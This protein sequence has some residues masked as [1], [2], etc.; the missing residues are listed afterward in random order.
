MVAQ[1]RHGHLLITGR[2]G[3]GKTTLFRQLA[4]ALEPFHPV[5]FYTE[6]IREGGSRL[7]FAAVS[8][9]GR[10][11]LLSHVQLPGPP[12]VGRYGVDIAGFEQFLAGVNLQQAPSSLIMIDEIGKMETCSLNFRSTLTGLLE[13]SKVIVATIALRGGGLIGAI[14]QRS[15]CTLVEV[16]PSNRERLLAELT[17]RI[18]RELQ[19]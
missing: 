17:D 14:K 18:R 5:G 9:D 6:E 4:R 2:P 3:V 19:P 11:Q 15:D 10:R 1:S 7:G 12:R 13:S 8:L 16:T